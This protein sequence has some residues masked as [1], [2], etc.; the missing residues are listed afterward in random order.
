MSYFL[1]ES[2]YLDD[3]YTKT[4]E[5]TLKNRGHRSALIDACGFLL[6]YWII[7]MRSY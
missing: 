1:A 6:F 7:S 5:I 3:F 4:L 2:T